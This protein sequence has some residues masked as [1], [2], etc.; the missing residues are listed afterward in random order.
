MKF[1]DANTIAR[2]IEKNIRGLTRV[3]SLARREDEVNDLDFL[4]MK[5]LYCI[6][7]EFKELY[8]LEICAMGNNVLFM[9]LNTDYG[10]IDIDIWRVIGY[11]HLER[12]KVLRTLDKGHNI[13]LRK[14]AK[15]MGLTLSEHGLYDKENNINIHFN[16]LKQLLD[17]LKVSY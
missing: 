10:T 6:A 9:K 7:N 13:Y 2:H 11:R 12:A 17:I 1:R 15:D 4:T 5:D 16:N 14:K 3:G 8:D